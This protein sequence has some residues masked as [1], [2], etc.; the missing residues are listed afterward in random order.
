MMKIYLSLLLSLTLSACTSGLVVRT[1]K[2][3]PSEMPEGQT[4]LQVPHG[5]REKVYVIEGNICSIYERGMNDY[6]IELMSMGDTSV[7]KRLIP[8]SAEPD[9][10]LLVDCSASGSTILIEDIIQKKFSVIDVR[11]VMD[12]RQQEIEMIPLSFFTQEMIPI[13]VGKILY[14]N[15]GSFRSNEP[16][17]FIASPEGD[18]HRLSKNGQK[19]LNVLDGT[20]L[21]NSAR[22]CVSFLSLYSPEI[23]FYGVRNK[24]PQQLISI[25]R[26][27]DVEVLDIFTGVINEYLFKNKA[28]QCFMCGTS[29][30]VRIAAAY[31]DELGQSHILLFDWD[32]NLTA[33]F[34]VHGDVWA[35]SLQDNFV[36][37]WERDK[38]KDRLVQ[39]DLSKY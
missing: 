30:A 35:V 29:D 11:E 3:L 26:N 31:R 17:F 19:S 37:C 4:I 6:V 24:R 22:G 34:D 1:I 16:R 14:L 9:G 13:G 27:E 33:G 7:V 23:E 38:D 36:Y 32:G 2:Y 20:L 15:Q 5:Q 8:Y 21:Y 39:Y 12:D 28:P 10:M 18:G 25:E